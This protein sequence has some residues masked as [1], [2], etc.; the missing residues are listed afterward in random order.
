MAAR[1]LCTITASRLTNANGT[2]VDRRCPTA[3]HC[4]AGANAYEITNTA[5]CPARLTLV[6]TVLNGDALPTAW[7]LTAT[8]PSGA[9]AGP[10]GTTGVTAPVTPLVTYPLSEIGG[11]P[12]YVQQAVAG[13]VA[14]PGSTISWF[15]SQVD[16][17]TGEVI[18]GF[19]DGLN[20]GVTIPD[21]F[22]VRCEARN[23]T[24]PL[25][26]IKQVIN[27]NGGTA[28]P[29]DWTLTATPTDPPTVPAGLLPQTVPGS[30]AGQ[31]IFVR[32]G[33]PYTLT[34]IDRAGLRA[35]RDHVC[36]Q[37]RSARRGS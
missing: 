19:S 14:I 4:A 15:C 23:Q 26:L 18:P 1:S 8:A 7:T 28:V 9:L 6:K 32:P 3:R 31:T 2:T 10:T 30:V 37:R 25:T 33:Q 36:D 21:G 20:G 29:G 24:A 17:T 16:P 22:A 12:R 13:A 11:D 34:E 27:D 5:T 35:D